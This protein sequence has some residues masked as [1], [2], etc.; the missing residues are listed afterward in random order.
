[1]NAPAEAP[2]AVPSAGAASAPVAAAGL[3]TGLCRTQRTLS[4]LPGSRRTHG[5]LAAAAAAGQHQGVHCDK[6]RAPRAPAAQTCSAWPRRRA[7]APRQSWPT[8]PGPG[9]RSSLRVASLHTGATRTAC[10]ATPSCAQACKLVAQQAK[11]LS[12]RPYLRIGSSLES[13]TTAGFLLASAG[14]WVPA[15]HRNP[16]A[17]AAVTRSSP[18]GL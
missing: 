13:P 9:W 14:P 15:D 4:G 17:S 6:A 18:G 1:M 3:A 12:G 8:S 10:L 5:T 7:A 16:L 11:V 2:S